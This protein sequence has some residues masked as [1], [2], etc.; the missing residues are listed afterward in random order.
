M[1]HAEINVSDIYKDV[2]VL[3]YGRHKFKMTAIVAS[4]CI[5]VDVE[6]RNPIDV[7]KVLVGQIRV[8]ISECMHS[9]FCIPALLYISEQGIYINTYAILYYICTYQNK[10]FV[11]IHIYIKNVHSF[12]FMI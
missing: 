10:V 12:I 5:R 7:Y 2:V 6:G 1:E 3:R 8:L 9:L 11:Y 4:N